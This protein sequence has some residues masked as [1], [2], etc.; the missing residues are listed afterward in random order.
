MDVKLALISSATAGAITI[1]ISILIEVFGGKVGAVLGS[2]PHVAVLGTIG[3]YYSLS[4]N[5]FVEAMLGMPVGMLSNTA[6]I[7]GFLLASVLM[8]TEWFKKYNGRRMLTCWFFALCLYSIT[9]FVGIVIFEACKTSIQRWLVASSC[10]VIELTVGML[11]KLIYKSSEKAAHQAFK[12][13]IFIRGIMTF[14]LFMIAMAVAHAIPALGGIL[15]NF[16][17]ISTVV[18]LSVWRDKGEEFTVGLCSPLILGMLSALAYCL[19]SGWIV[20]IQGLTVGI[21]ISWVLSI[22]LITL[23]M[24]YFQ[25]RAVPNAD[26]DL[27]SAVESR[28]GEARCNLELMSVYINEVD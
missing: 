25:T 13:E 28:C 27:N 16:P 8:P 21:V 24:L 18:L 12:L 1:T 11:L 19:F 15:V 3:F 26:S 22:S 14:G 5:D 10:F 17:T 6:Y 23:P 20:P 4:E 9:A 2:V 7:A